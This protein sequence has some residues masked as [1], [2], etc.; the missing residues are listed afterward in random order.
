MARQAASWRSRS[1]NRAIPPTTSLCPPR[2]LV[3]EWT[4]TAAP[5]S[6]GRHRYGEATVLS[7]TR[8]TPAAAPTSARAGRSATVRVGLATVSA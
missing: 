5:C 8:G 3:A 6:I 7:T 4:T 1:A 2:Y